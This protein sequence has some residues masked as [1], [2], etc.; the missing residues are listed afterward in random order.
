MFTSRFESL[1]GQS[2][3]VLKAKPRVACCLLVLCG[4]GLEPLRAQE[5]YERWRK[6][7]EGKFQQFVEQRDKDFVAFLKHEWKQMQLMHGLVPNEKPKPVQMP[8]FQPTQ[9]LPP[10]DTTGSRTVVSLPSVKPLLETPPAAIERPRIDPERNRTIVKPAF[11]GFPLSVSFDEAMRISLD[12][13]VGKETIS[14][15]WEKMSQTNYPDL[16]K[17]TSYFVREMHLN[18]WGLMELFHTL[19]REIYHSENEAVLFTWFLASKS[20]YDAKVGFS[21]EK[22]SLLIPT[23][24]KLYAV[25]FFTLGKTG[26]RYYVASL[27]PKWTMDNDRIYTY[28]GDYPQASGLVMFALTAP[29]VLEEKSV[30]KSLKFSY[31][32]QEHV[33]PVNVSADAVRFF[34][35]YPQ[36]NFEVYFDALPSRNASSSLQAAL[37]PLVQGRTEKDAVGILLRF[38]QTAFGYKTDPEQFGRE[39]P[40]FPDETLYYDFS[41]CEDRAI[42]FAY[43]VRTLTGLKVIGLDYPG[44][45]ATAV[46]FTDDVHGDSVIYL[47][48]KYVICDPTYVNADVGNCMPDFKT[49]EP[50][51]IPIE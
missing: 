5:D 29:P 11:Y 49:I 7:E 22:V 25:P 34:E 12:L 16:L 15:F 3:M 36:T 13:P 46:R 28:E 38:A 1:Q 33:V 6:Q 17:Q 24:N 8:I 41:D 37:R 20:G 10:E 31:A 23:G 43:L 18:D 51:V 19:G 47:G 2:T 14:R 35:Y 44:H 32:G 39:K 9:K 45:V 42:L 30:S 50:K 40:L 4:V 27:D 48:K 26:R 21:G